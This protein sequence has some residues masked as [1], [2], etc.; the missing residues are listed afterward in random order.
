[1][2]VNLKLNYSL[3]YCLILYFIFIFTISTEAKGTI[4]SLVILTVV[5]ENIRSDNGNIRVHLYEYSNKNSFPD[6]S[7]QANQLRVVKINSGKAIARFENL[8]PGVYAFT[9]HHDENLNVKM[10]RNFVGLPTEGWALSNNVKPLFKLP[11][12]EECSFELKSNKRISININ[13]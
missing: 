9:V 2:G 8:L 12:F 13:Y 4:D 6:K 7:S 10:D 3:L 5:V 1:M 11:N